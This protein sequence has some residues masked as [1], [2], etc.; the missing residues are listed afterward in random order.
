VTYIGAE[1]ILTSLGNSAETNF[2]QL[3]DGISGIQWF[4]GRGVNKDGV[5]LSKINKEGEVAKFGEL[6]VQSLEA[7]FQRVDKTIIQSSRT[8]VFISSTKG[9]LAGNLKDPFG[10]SVAAVQSHFGLKN[11][12][13]VVSNACISGVLAINAAN[14]LINAGSYDHVVVVGCD[15]I[16]DFVLFGFQSLYAV[17]SEPCRPFDQNRKGVTLGEGAATVVVSN[18]KDIFSEVPL[19]MLGGTSSNDANHISGPSRT[20]EGLVRSVTRT[21]EA[22]GVETGEIDFISAHGTAT[23]F[24]DEMESIAFDRLGM[25]AVSLN[26][27]K[28]YFGHTLGAAGVIETAICMQSMRNYKL[29]RSLGYSEIGTSKELNILTEN[30]KIEVNTVLK[31]A[32]GFGG[33]NASLI[34]RK[35]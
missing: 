35:L 19:E 17:S 25:S 3:S 24:N 29:I 21:L 34:L 14:D 31:T 12:P 15:V 11:Y 7:A 6:V 9:D 5:F 30:K 22:T 13:L 32:S 16:T 2:Q 8:L 33:C 10:K 1:H 23:S 4:E 26:S 18:S 20:G 28:G 27:L